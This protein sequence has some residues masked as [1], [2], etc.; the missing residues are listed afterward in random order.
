MHTTKKNIFKRSENAII[1]GTTEPTSPP[2]LGIKSSTQTGLVFVFN[3]LWQ[4]TEPPT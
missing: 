3:H 1:G 2:S 4:L